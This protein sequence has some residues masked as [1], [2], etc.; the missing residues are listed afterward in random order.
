MTVLRARHMLL[1]I[2]LGLL[3]MG[4]TFVVSPWQ[5]SADSTAELPDWA[6]TLLTNDV[7]IQADDQVT[8]IKTAVST[9]GSSTSAINGEAITYTLTISNS[10]D[11]P[12]I[13]VTVIDLLPEDALEDFVL[14][15][16]CEADYESQTVPDP[17]G[18]SITVTRTR[19][20]RWELT[21]VAPNSSVTTTF[22]GRIV[23]QT[24]G[25]VLTNVAFIEYTQDGER[26]SGMSNKI[27]TIVNVSYEEDGEASFSSAPTWLSDDLGGSLT[28]DWGDYDGDGDQDMAIAST[29]GTYIYRNDDGDLIPVWNNELLTFGVAWFDLMQD[30]TLA[31]VAVGESADGTPSTAGSNYI[32]IPDGE[33]FRSISFASDLQL[34]RVA[35]GDYDEDGDQD[36][37][38]ST[39]AV[40]ADDPILVYKNSGV[41]EHW[42]D[43]GST[44]LQYYSTDWSYATA[45]LSSYDLNQDGDLD[46]AL[47]LFPNYMLTFLGST[48]DQFTWG[49]YDTTPQFLPYDF[50]W[51]DYD[52]DGLLDLAAAYP[53]ERCARI[54]HASANGSLTEAYEIRTNVFRTP[55]ALDWG[56]MDGD[57]M[58]DLILAD[59]PPRVYGF[60]GTDWNEIMT[61]PSSAV[62]GQIWSLE[63]ADADGDGDLDIAMTNRDGASM[64][65]S[66]AVAMLTTELTK[67][68]GLGTTALSSVAWGDVDGDEDVDLLFGAGS[69]TVASR[70]YLNRSAVF[71]ASYSTSYLSSGFGPQEASFG[72]MD[73]DGSLDVAIA[74][75]TRSGVQV[76]IKELDSL[77]DWEMSSAGSASKSCAWVDFDM[78]GWLDLS[79]ANKGANAVYLND[80]GMLQ[81]SAFWTSE[82]TDD[83]R[84]LA[85]ADIDGDLDL[86]LAVANYNQPNRLYRN[87]GTG[88]T[89][90]WSSTFISSTTSVAW[91]DVDADGD[92][93][94]SFGNYGQANTIYLNIDGELEADPSWVSEDTANTVS[95]AWGDCNNDSYPDLAVGNSGEGD[96]VYLNNGTQADSEPRLHWAWT[97]PAYGTTDLAWGDVD[98]DGDLDLAVSASDGNSGYY[99][100]NYIVPAH[101]ATGYEAGMT[102]P[103]NSTYVAVEKPGTTDSAYGMTSS[104]VL[105]GPDDPEVTIH[106]TVYDPDGSRRP[107]LESDAVGD[108]ILSTT[109]EFSLDDGGTWQIATPAASSP[110]PITTTSRLGQE[111]T[112]LWDAVADE[113]ISDQALFR[114]TV[115]SDN[116]E[117]TNRSSVSG[118]SPS[119][120]V[121]GVT[122]VWPED[123]S[124]TIEQTEFS[125]GTAISFEG[126]VGHGTGVLSFIWD[127]GDG[128]TDQGQTVEHTYTENGVYVVTLTVQSEATPVV[129]EVS[130]FYTISFGSSANDGLTVNIPLVVNGQGE[131]TENIDLASSIQSAESTVSLATQSQNVAQVAAAPLWVE[132]QNLN[133][134]VESILVENSDISINSVGDV[135][136]VTVGTPYA[137]TTSYVAA[138][139]G[140][141]A[142]TSLN[143][144]GTKLAFW[145]TINPTNRNSDGS[146]EVYSAKKSGTSWTLSQVSESAGSVLGGFNLSPVE[147][148]DGSSLAF[149]SDRDLVGENADANFEI[150]TWSA[151]ILT[152][153]THTTGGVNMQPSLN[154]DG[155]LVAFLSDR[156]LVEGQKVAEGVQDVFLLDITTGEIRR[157]STS[158]A[159]VVNDGPVLSSDG[160]KLAVVSTG[161]W[162]TSVGNADHSAEIFVCDIASGTW[163]QVTNITTPDSSI[164]VH[165]VQIDASGEH[166][167]F[168]SGNSIV[169]ASWQGSQYSLSVI[170]ATGGSEY[171]E[172]RICADGLRVAFIENDNNLYVYDTAG[173]VLTNIYTSS[174]DVHDLALSGEGTVVAFYVDRYLYS[175]IV[176]RVDVSVEATAIP[177][178]FVPGLSAG[179]EVILG[180][181]GPSIAS[182]TELKFNIPTCL[183]DAS[184]EYVVGS[185]VYTGTTYAFDQDFDLAAGQSVTVYVTGDLATS[186]TVTVTMPITAT[187]S[188]AVIDSLPPNEILT[189][190]TAIDGQA[191]LRGRINASA[192]RVNEDEDVVFTLTVNNLGPG[193]AP[194][195][196]AELDVPDGLTISDYVAD[197]GTFADDVWELGTLLVGQSVEIEIKASPDEGTG[198]TD[199]EFAIGS[200][201]S[202]FRDTDLTNNLDSATIAVNDPPD[203]VADSYTVDEGETLS[204]TKTSEGVLA[205][206][207][208]SEGDALTVVTTPVTDTLHGDLTLYANGT[209]TYVHDGSETTSDRFYYR[210]VD[211]LGASAIA[212]VSITVTPVNDAPTA[213]DLSS[214][215]VDENMP[216]GSPVGS[217]LATD[218]DSDAFT[219]SLESTPGDGDADNNKFTIDG[220][221]LRTAAVFDYETKSSYNIHVAVDDLDGGTFERNFVITVVDINDYPT[222]VTLSSSTINENV[223]IGTAVGTL[224]LT[225]V[226]GP[227]PY[228]FVL[229]SGTGSGDNAKFSIDGDSL[230]TAVAINYEAQSSFSIRVR[231]SDAD[232]GTVEQAFTI[233]ALDQNDPPTAIALSNS[234]IAE[235][236]PS[237]TLVGT[238]SATDQDAGE[239]FTFSLVSGTG[240]DDNAEFQVAS[241]NQL[242]TAAILDYEAGATRSIRVRV[243]DSDGDFY[244]RAFTIQVSDANDAPTA[245]NLD[246][247]SVAENQP[248]DTIVGALSADD[249]DDETF[250]YA[251]VAG[252]GD[253]NN[254]SFQISGSNLLTA[255]SFNYEVKSSYSIRVRVTDSASNTFEQAL[256][257]TI[258]N[259]NEAPTAIALSA[260][261]V[262]ESATVGTIVGTLSTTDPDT[263]DTHT[264]TITAS[265]AAQ[266]AFTI[267]GNE[268]RVAAALDY[269]TTPSYSLTVRSTDSGGLT[270]THTWTITVTDANDAPTAIALSA[271]TVAENAT[272]G[273]VVGTLSTTD[274]DAGDAHTYTITA[275]AAAQAAFTIVGNEL[276]VNA[277]LD[278]E[279]TPSYSITIRSTDNGTPSQSTT[280]TWTITVTNVN[281]APTSISLTNTSIAEDA[282]I[283]TVVGTLSTTDQDAGDTHIYTITGTAA[284][285]AAFTIVGNELRVNAA[286]DF[287][288]TP[289]YSLTVQSTDTG[290]LSTTHTWT[291]TITDVAE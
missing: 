223:A 210:V 169:L 182:G 277:A 78:D 128:S 266:A 181:V 59:Q 250:T 2:S 13:D 270:T 179:Y 142:N 222:A 111:G 186:Q 230:E 109:F 19:Q 23:G 160:Q 97:S 227:T 69:G 226:D 118:T 91:I 263:N 72:D 8:L 150:F 64:T 239:T 175:G 22:S 282:A 5:V 99:E 75:G 243:V 259:V 235:N 286:L 120:R 164:A 1:P 136:T 77:P 189:I 161:N 173:N 53:L 29:V 155:T 116:S 124:I 206:D 261:T 41:A 287:E 214:T 272:V 242:K 123:P 48:L 232:G 233:T 187:V 158:V 104:E 247:S 10:T 25:T 281:E 57:G 143:Y 18:E 229:V 190:E 108:L 40:N 103:N 35:P 107:D 88:M 50:A 195:A 168:L 204:I 274:Q 194:N 215:D 284:A 148:A 238:L 4:L 244:E 12:L 289:S 34:V 31:L 102:L 159:G 7:S 283:G 58:L 140:V 267:V 218:V 152:Q 137:M 231:G 126:S 55:L 156:Q 154:E 268:L 62:Q 271:T 70:A 117:G 163:T 198:G 28:L 122:E 24:D 92:M 225:D 60:D 255:A 174:L 269:E 151:G 42:F 207:Y 81:D 16:E 112:F 285:Q 125:V 89:L 279:T 130:T 258:T 133:L 87:D 14:P 43:G 113:A 165:G 119:F 100:N 32:Y 110:E 260:T 184:W 80:E 228:S 212:R 135:I 39:N 171:S 83:S 96:Q 273:T 95:I 66:S 200:L 209:F 56:D 224:D 17:L 188:S 30:G 185:T 46:L 197:Q 251:L 141:G 262:A 33:T 45:A 49:S 63:A 139:W 202:D 208:D 26:N 51:G 52:A 236:E 38:V 146:I 21:E 82:E 145:S 201:S 178:P 86:D 288:T 93:D 219:Y 203:A 121:R 73:G 157:L 217:F 241:G 280:E 76:Y 27:R 192:T 167:A 245:I 11:I 172:V 264:Y 290:E 275:S 276:R 138:Y 74:L 79:V 90:I 134:A 106:Y 15:P 254:A 162:D 149:F 36:L 37:I 115:V 85:W 131:S 205:N 68:T 193:D 105:S 177:D 253:T 67:V 176:P 257:V 54:Y 147:S 234:S 170:E 144:D 166:L 3:L 246:P 211:A 248:S 216:I 237:G 127:F 265:A 129:R 61:L 132:Q 98:E 20:I 9:T 196:I 221:I 65:F 71:N 47:G 6:E 114:V 291:I 180:N 101:M 153:R 191:D 213:L 220:N 84:A 249:I 44:P 240:D 256:Q 94:L 183:L 199:L 252:T 278:F